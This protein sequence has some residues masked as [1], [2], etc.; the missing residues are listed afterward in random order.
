MSPHWNLPPDHDCSHI[1]C[2]VETTGV[3]RSLEFRKPWLCCFRNEYFA[4]RAAEEDSRDKQP[5]GAQMVL[6][7]TYQWFK[8][9]NQNA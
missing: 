2:S 5:R 6:R 1:G 4:A 8:G 7:S 3:V 9:N